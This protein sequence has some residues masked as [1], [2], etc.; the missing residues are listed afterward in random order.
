M[1]AG[2]IQLSTVLKHQS[3]GDHK[4]AVEA[5][6]MRRALICAETMLEP[7]TSNS[8]AIS[9]S[10]KTLFATVYFAAQRGFAGHWSMVCWIFRD[11]TT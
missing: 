3:S 6:E 7:K 5:D 10:D 8:P 1:G 4:A 9:A 2:N 11:S